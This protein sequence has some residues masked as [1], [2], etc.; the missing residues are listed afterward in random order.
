[1][2]IKKIIVTGILI[3]TTQLLPGQSRSQFDQNFDSVAVS[4]EENLNPYIE[5]FVKIQFYN[6]PQTEEQKLLEKSSV[7][8]YLQKAS[9]LRIDLKK[10]LLDKNDTK[11]MNKKQIFGYFEIMYKIEFLGLDYLYYEKIRTQ[12]KISSG[13]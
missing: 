8:I 7:N 5:K 13:N 4:F 11:N 6:P 3:L 10:Q 2:R 12:L 9:N 1:M